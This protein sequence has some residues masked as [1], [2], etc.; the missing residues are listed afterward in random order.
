MQHYEQFKNGNILFKKF[1]F[2][3]LNMCTFKEVLS[4]KIYHCYCFSGRNYDFF[5][6]D[7]QD[8]T[9]MSYT[10]IIHVKISYDKAIE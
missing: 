1:L 3:S 6:K 10:R 7:I 5:L 9:T 4:R 8:L 2:S